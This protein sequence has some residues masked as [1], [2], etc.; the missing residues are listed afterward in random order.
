MTTGHGEG[1]PQENRI[2]L[3]L[4][5]FAATTDGYRGPIGE[6]IRFVEDGI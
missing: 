3:G 6:S 1:T 4:S 5:N 2:A